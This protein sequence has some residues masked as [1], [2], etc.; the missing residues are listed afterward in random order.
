MQKIF[1]PRSVAQDLGIPVRGVYRLLRQGKIRHFRVG[2]LIRI[3]ES[4]FEQYIATNIL[5]SDISALSGNEGG[6]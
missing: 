2:R 4:D 5:S 6:K 1:T 3:R